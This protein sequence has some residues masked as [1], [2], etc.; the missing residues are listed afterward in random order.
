MDG[1]KIREDWIAQLERVDTG[2]ELS[3]DIEWAFY[4]QDLMILTC[5]HK[6][7]L[8]RDKIIDLLDDCNFHTEAGL[9]DEQRYDDCL[10]AIIDDMGIEPKF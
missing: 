10:K 3:A 9:L 1:Q 4:P 8:F 7:G 6:A 2:S 5:L